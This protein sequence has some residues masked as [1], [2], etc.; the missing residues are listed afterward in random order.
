[1]IL[2][3]ETGTITVKGFSAPVRTHRVVGLHDGS[4]IEGRIIR[5]EQEGLLLII[6]QKKL[7]SEGRADAIRALQDAVGRL[8]ES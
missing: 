6:D 2:A 8:R 5:Q 7:T 1:M 4:G 3:E